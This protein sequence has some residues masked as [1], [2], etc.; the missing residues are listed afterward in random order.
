MINIYK[1]KR[2]SLWHMGLVFL[3]AFST[4]HA[5]AQEVVV[6]GKVTD[7]ETEQGLPG[8]SVRV[9][10]TT[11]GTVTDVDG[12][13]SLSVSASGVVKIEISFV[14]YATATADVQVSNGSTAPINVALKAEYSALDEVVVTGTGVATSRKQLGNYIST[15]KS[16]D[17]VSGAANNPLAALQG[18]VAGAQIMQNNGN[19][20]GGFTVRLRG[21]SSI[22]GSSE[23]L[24]II[25]GVIVNNNTNNLT[26][27][28]IGISGNNDFS[29][30]SN[31]LVDINPNDIDRVEVLNGAAAS[32]LYGSRAS[33][34]VVQ[35]FTK[36]GT[37]GK[38]SITFSTSV[39]VSELRKRIDVNKE[40]IRFGTGFNRFPSTPAEINDQRLTSILLFNRL[41]PNSTPVTRYDYQDDIFR[42]GIGTDN[43]LSIA[44]G[45]EKTKY[46]FSG[47]YY[48]NEGIIKGTD[49]SRYNAKLRIDQ[50]LNSWAKASLGLNYIRSNVNELP[51]GNSFYSPM[52]ALLI[53]DNVYNLNERDANGNLLA[54]EPTRVN[55][56]SV[57]EGVKMQNLTNRIIG[58]FQ[59]TLTPIDGLRIEYVSGIDT[60][61]QLGQ[62]FIG[63]YPYPNVNLAFFA[64]GYASTATQQVFQINNDLNISYQKNI[65]SKIE[66][67]TVLGGT[68]QYDN[69]NFTQAQGRDMIPGIETI[70]GA[71]NVFVVPTEFKSERSIQGA[72]LQQTFSYNEFLFLTAAGRIDGAS[73]FG[74]NN[75][76]QFYPKASASLLLSELFKGSSIVNKFNLIKLRIAYGQ[77]GNLTNLTPYGR[78]SNYDPLAYV[79]N[80]RPFIRN[81]TQGNPNVGPERQT[82][83]EVGLDIGVL[84]NRVGLEINLYDKKVTDLLLDLTL[85]PSTGSANINT[86][87]GTLTNRGFEIVVK[88]TPIKTKDFTWNVTG[89]FNKNINQVN[90]P[91]NVPPVIRF[92][93]DANRMSSAIN[94]R[95]LGVFYGT[96]YARNADGSI[97]LTASPRTVGAVTFQP[98]LPAVDRVSR[99]ATT[100]L[101]T[102]ALVQRELGDPNP[103]WTGSLLNEFAYK[104][105]TARFL[106]DAVQGFSVN[107]L[108]W[109]TYN[110][111]GAGLLAAKE[112][113]GEIPRGTV[114]II[115]GFGDERIREEMIE[116]GSFV[117]M[118]ELS[119]GYT[120]VPGIK[121]ITN[122]S[123]N[124]IGRNLYSWDSYRGWDPE[125]NSGGQ[126]NRI[127]G[128]DFGTVPIPRTYQLSVTAKF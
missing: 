92:S 127:R 122:L 28:S 99:D 102:G 39:T 24:Y 98:G 9:V 43:Y 15:I 123:I 46:L 106:L 53:T 54:V 107:N 58:D 31:R 66:S 5:Q 104:G 7:A 20:A 111:V 62:T 76:I 114:S 60:Y 126:S 65:T 45:N 40:P 110:N 94:G 100:G 26:D 78:F 29:P 71:K 47:S 121:G 48:K 63:R 80:S 84:N 36:R 38:P 32:A 115:G 91:D 97:Y 96:A 49:F 86:N 27:L 70:N 124:L 21:A 117:K 1:Q 19:P 103:N 72:F 4:L 8:A 25:D 116:S 12:N 51:D 17:L 69:S 95:P 113:R 22:V 81:Q 89:I 44:G 88:G 35:I 87:L 75:R 11:T 34:G 118:R 77:S 67:T 41:F 59:L 16:S 33:N 112:L 14:G 73:P 3:L 55:P 50:T 90:L 105:F 82:E 128:D 83:I 56:L 2:R 6:N 10:G 108:N 18:K 109:T 74:V 57:I 68:I 37:T 13:F 64:D 42:Q 61:S 79:G 125:V 119:F 52:N 101:P 85:A 120:F 30:G 93:A 23:P